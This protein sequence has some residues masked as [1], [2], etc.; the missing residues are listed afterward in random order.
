MLDRIANLWSNS[1][2]TVIG[3]V[4]LAPIVVAVWFLGGLLF[5]WVDQTATL[6][7]LDCKATPYW[8]DCVFAHPWRTFTAGSAIGL[9]LLCLIAGGIGVLSLGLV[10]YAKWCVRPLKKKKDKEPALEWRD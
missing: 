6:P 1:K 5:V 8:L 4:L 10:N 9:V 3:R 2:R 7:T